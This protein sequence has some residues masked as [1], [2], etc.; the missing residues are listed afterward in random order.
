MKFT[1]ILFSVLLGFIISTNA[2]SAQEEPPQADPATNESA[3]GS[4]STKAAELSSET[5]RS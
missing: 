4:D 3:A 1:A 2:L 5:W